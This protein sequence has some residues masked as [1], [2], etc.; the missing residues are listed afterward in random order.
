[1]TTQLVYIGTWLLLGA[2]A[3]LLVVWMQDEIRRQDRRRLK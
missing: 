2:P 1:M 3:L